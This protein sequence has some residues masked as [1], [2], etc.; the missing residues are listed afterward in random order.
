MTL[1]SIKMKF[2]AYAQSA[3]IRRLALSLLCCAGLS[4]CA[5]GGVTGDI[6]HNDPY[7]PFNRRVFEFNRGLD[8]TVIKPAAKGYRAMLPQFVRDRIRSIIDNLNEPLIF[9]NDVLQLRGD[10]ASATFGRFFINSIAGLGGMFDRAGAD[11]L[12]KQTGDFGQTLYRWG[13]SDGPYLVLP[14]FGPSNVRDAF[15]LG[16]DFVTSPVS[17]AI[18]SGDRLAF[19][20]SVGGTN[21]IDLRERNLESLDVLE[22]SSLDFYVH[23]RSVSRQY[24][25]AIL[26]EARKGDKPAE[27]L[28]PDAPAR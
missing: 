26:N 22:Q 18:P 20:L 28:D 3:P 25:A 12:P 13:A 23:L 19:G 2:P 9:V 7:E 17:Y 27:L 21:G 14:F 24:R 15:G 1:V 4:G 8:R 10:A 6:E 16:V 11:G 5:T